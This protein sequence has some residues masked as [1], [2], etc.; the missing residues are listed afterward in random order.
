[1]PP[2]SVKHWTQSAG[3]GVSPTFRTLFV[4]AG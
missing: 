1:V 3:R 2:P 4:Q